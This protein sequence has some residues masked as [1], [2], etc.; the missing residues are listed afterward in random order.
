MSLLTK[1]VDRLSDPGSLALYLSSKEGAE[2]DFWRK[3]IL[4]YEQWLTGEIPVLYKTPSPAPEE[5][6]A[7]PNRRDAAVLTWHR[8]HQERKY[9][10]DL[11][12]PPDAFAGM[13]LLD[14]GAGP[15]PSATCFSGAQIY[16][17]EPLLNRYL[18]AGFPIHYYPTVTYV[19][20]T[21]ER[22]PI[23]DGF[24]DAAIS[25]NAIDHVN[26]IGQTAD[27]IRRVLKPGG[28]LRL[29]VHY[30]PP[31]RCEPIHLDDA[32]VAALFAWCPGLRKISQTQE[33][34]S[35]SIGGNE[36]FAVWSNFS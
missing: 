21:S 2:E 33:N 31:T 25:V 11:D 22:I 15:M 27:E 3:E 13:K 9:L 24:F 7:A 1:V 12:L 17:L 26:D 29:H 34:Y 36:S 14:V 23:E 19:H 28:K 30:H 8:K 20:A 6:V 32:R 18:T 10:R 5:V 35:H 4:K 16:C